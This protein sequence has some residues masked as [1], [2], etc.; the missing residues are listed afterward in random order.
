[1]KNIQN[2]M[3]LFLL[4]FGVAE[5]QNLTQ[6]IKGTIV[7]NESQSTLEGATVVIMKGEFQTGTTTDANGLFKIEKVPVGR[8][9]IVVRFMGYETATLSE[10]MVSSGKE[11][12]LNINLKQI[13][14]KV[15]EVTIKANGRKDLALNS[16]SAISARSFTVEETRRYAGG[17]DDPA[18]M[19][20]AFAGVT[21]GNIQDNAIVIRGN[22]PKGVAWHLEG[23]EIPNPNHFAGGNVAGG[24]VVTI[25]SSQ[26]L[27]NSDFFTGA[28]PSE[29]GNALA[30]VFDM[31]LRTGNPDKREHTFQAGLLGI[32]V[33]SEGPI[34]LGKK[35]TYLFNY[36]LSSLSLLSNLKIVPSEQIPRYQDVSFKF[37]FPTKAGNFSLWAVAGDDKNTEPVDTDS[38]KWE[39]AWDR[40]EYDWNL[41]MG[42]AGLSHK[43]VLDK[44]SYIN[45]T[46]AVTGTSN[47][48][49]MRRV[50]DDLE[51]K[52]RNYF[53]DKSGRVAFN[54][55]I[56]SKISPQLTVRT[57]VTVN[58]LFYNI[59]L[60]G[61]LH[62]TSQVWINYA[63]Q[64]GQTT[65]SEWYIQSKYTLTNNFTFNFGLNTSYFAVNQDFSIDPR[66]GLNWNILPNHTLSFGYGKHSQIEDLRFYYITDEQNGSTTFPN[67]DLGL[68]HAHHIVLGYDWLISD[69]LRLKVEPYY[70]H[71]YNVPGIKDS[72]YSMINFSQDWNFH[73]PLVNNSTGRN[74]GIDFTFERFFKDNFYYL[75]TLS[76]FDSKYKGG[77]GVWRNTRFNKQYACNL[78]VGKEIFTK[79]DRVLGLNARLNLMGGERM[80]PLL[81]DQSLELKDVVYDESKA[82]T[83]QGKPVTYL[84]VTITWKANHARYTG[85]WALQVKNALA[86]GNDYGYYYNYRSNSLEKDVARVVLP[87]LSYKIEF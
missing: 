16:M 43:L 6:T 37:Y 83:Q 48:M 22:S 23:V 14:M 51:L 56:N 32:D 5:A 8:Y 76:V 24:G 25:F 11:V 65:Y 63:R 61:T 72:S 67:K 26:L 87:V 10:I 33:A 80:S 30:G 20:S 82:F 49:D 55:Y 34:M 19:A 74:V 15:D 68:A 71:I 58:Q 75:V 85:T 69:A 18:R 66:F 31:K 44:Q 38:S 42:A 81:R 2:V 78:L 57:G 29:Y 4:S 64:K 17:L 53:S 79:K 50:S 86:A 62:D 60:N 39:S 54:S 41:R 28:F 52:N 45:S 77:D 70:Q 9:N 3:L 59:D 21:V 36:R 84:D 73:H 1:M 27:A 7:D 12:V 46:L 35:A 13:A 47:V 40:V